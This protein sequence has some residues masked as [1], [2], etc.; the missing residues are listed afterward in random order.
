MPRDDW[1]FDEPDDELADHEYPDEDSLD[2]DSE[3]LTDTLPCPHCGADVYED[4]ECC[5][6]CGNY[7]IRHGAALSG[8][9][10]WWILLG[11]AGVA[12]VIVAA[13]VYFRE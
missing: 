11:V 3:D 7:I 5:P 6:N 9:P 1:Y 2:E 12:A 13:A 10:L 4:A 8:R